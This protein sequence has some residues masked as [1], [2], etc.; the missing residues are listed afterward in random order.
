MSA[1]LKQVVATSYETIIE[2]LVQHLSATLK[3]VIATSSI[4]MNQLEKTRSNVVE[5][6]LK[7]LSRLLH[8]HHRKTYN[9][10][11]EKHMSIFIS[12]LTKQMQ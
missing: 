7:K 9:C 4:I 10:N 5:N 1:T 8:L 12:I 6:V 2:K 3:Q 11:I